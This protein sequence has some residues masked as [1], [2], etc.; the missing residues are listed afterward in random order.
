MLVESSCTPPLAV[1]A[2]SLYIMY[3]ISHASRATG[4][5]LLRPQPKWSQNLL[6]RRPRRHLPSPL[7]RQR[8]NNTIQRMRHHDLYPGRFQIIAPSRFPA[9]HL[10][11]SILSGDSCDPR[12]LEHLRFCEGGDVL[13]SLQTRVLVN[14]LRGE[15]L[16]EGGGF[17]EQGEGGLQVEDSLAEE[18]EAVV[19]TSAAVVEGFVGYCEPLVRSLKSAT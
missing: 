11:N 9:H 6:S 5:L 15:G 8:P 1:D 3:A 14:V 4:S 2:Q 13:G 18:G 16:R 10:I 12:F 7:Q 19:E 17:G